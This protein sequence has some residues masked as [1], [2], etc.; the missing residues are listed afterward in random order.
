M[1]RKKYASEQKLDFMLEFNE[2]EFA[3]NVFYAYIDCEFC[4]QQFLKIGT[5]KPPSYEGTRRLIVERY[6]K[7]SPIGDVTN[8]Q[9]L[10]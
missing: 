10:G 7:D 8:I 9:S 1:P 4:L 6:D 2:L 5:E 3:I